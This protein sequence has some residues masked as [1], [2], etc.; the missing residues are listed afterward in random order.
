MLNNNLYTNLSLKTRIIRKRDFKN[1]LNDEI[2]DKN[3]TNLHQNYIFKNRRSYRGSMINLSYEELKN[4]IETIS[5]RTN[6]HPIPIAGNI[7][8][9]GS[10]CLNKENLYYSNFLNDSFNIFYSSSLKNYIQRQIN[11]S[12]I[13]GNGG[14]IFLLCLDFNILKSKYLQQSDILSWVDLGCLLEGMSI[15][16]ALQSYRCC[17]HFFIQDPVEIVFNHIAYTPVCIFRIGHKK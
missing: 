17:I 2:F 4:F 8:P 15:I 10:F 12:D 13:K 14:T 5:R 3:L 11:R 6:Y 7:S 16:T 9:L 1:I